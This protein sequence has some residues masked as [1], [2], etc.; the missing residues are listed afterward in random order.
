[1]STNNSKKK[2]KRYR[3]RY[4]RVIA[5]SVLFIVLIV[6]LVSCIGKCSDGNEQASGNSSESQSSQIIEEHTNPENSVVES[7]TVQ[8]TQE[9]N[10]DFLNINV[11]Y[12]SINKGDLVLVNKSYEYKFT[13]ELDIADVFSNKNDCYT[14]KDMEVY[15]ESSVISK[16][17]LFMEDYK[18]A[19]NNTDIR[20]IEAYLSKERHEE[21]AASNKSNAPVGFS[22]YNTARTFDLASFPPDGSSYYLL[23]E[24]V[25]SWI[26][27]N[28]AKYGFILRYPVGKE[29]ITGIPSSTYTFRYVGIPHAIYI[30]QND[31]TLEEYIEKIKS[32]NIENPL[33][34]T[35]GTK[36]YDIYYVPAN[37]DSVTEVP[38]PSSRSY[39]ISGN[40]IDG[41]I[42]T[43]TL[44]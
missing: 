15:L 14:V 44:N 40:N 21:K 42:I 5:V 29:L 28:A 1:M 7:G 25:Y 12:S 36:N 23:N 8:T 24:G 20:V 37:A 4:D 41:F 22:D 31:L 18:K 13:E 26:Y 38:V 6:M 39:T 27:E 33:K 2:K 34:V 43:V 10:P 17:N 19:C 9:S 16:F 35:D 30:A 3:L 11:E 32:Y